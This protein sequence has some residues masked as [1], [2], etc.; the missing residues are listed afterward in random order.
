MEYMLGK[1][2]FILALIAAA[3]FLVAAFTNEAPPNWAIMG[4]L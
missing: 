2:D 3:I 1:F 4:T